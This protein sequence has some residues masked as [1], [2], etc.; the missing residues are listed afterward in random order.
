[1]MAFGFA[2]NNLLERGM[3]KSASNLGASKNRD[4]WGI[5]AKVHLFEMAGRANEGKSF[6][7]EME[8]R[9]AG[10]QLHQHIAWHQVSPNQS[11]TEFHKRIMEIGIGV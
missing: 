9:W 7:K 5:H 8:K 3:E 4:I 6:V 1:M 10:S 11:I 2:E